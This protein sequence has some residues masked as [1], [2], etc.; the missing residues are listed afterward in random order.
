MNV[1]NILFNILSLFFLWTH[2]VGLSMQVNTE[3]Y[4]NNGFGAKEQI[5][6]SKDASPSEGYIKPYSN[7]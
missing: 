1:L 2:K 3:I 7:K 4:L 6:S 5:N